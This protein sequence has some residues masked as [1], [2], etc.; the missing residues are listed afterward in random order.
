ME[1][2]QVQIFQDIPEYKFL[3]IDNWYTPEEEKA[4]WKELDYYS[5][6]PK[7]IIERAENSSDTAKAEGKTLAK[8]YRF[9]PDTLYAYGKRENSTILRLMSKQNKKEFHDILAPLTPQSRAFLNSNADCSLI[10]YYEDSD[11]YKPHTDIFHWTMLIWFVR[12]PR[13]FTGGDFNLTDIDTK[14]KLKHNRAVFFP[15]NYM[16][17][18]DPLK[19]EKQSDEMGYGRYTITHFYYSIAGKP[20]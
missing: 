1:Q 11:Y 19:F 3:L 20:V 10:S 13:I 2:W 15:S 9:Y 6:I 18:V 7:D 14:I 16:H 5:S 12:E 4:V 17:S 8:A